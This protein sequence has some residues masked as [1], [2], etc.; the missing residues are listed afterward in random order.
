MLQLRG[1]GYCCALALLALG[2]AVAIAPLR[3]QELALP[4]DAYPAFDAARAFAAIAPA[5]DAPAAIVPA[6]ANLPTA[7]EGAATAPAENAPLPGEEPS[8]EHVVRLDQPDG[9]PMCNGGND[10]WDWQWVP[11]GIIYHSYMAGPQEPR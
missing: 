3:A 6:A 1:R 11:A 2:S 10:G 7:S 5:T 8:S 4:P 9:E